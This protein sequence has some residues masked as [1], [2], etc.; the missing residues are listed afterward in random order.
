MSFQFEHS[1]S[2]WV[3][4]SEYEWKEATDGRL[5]LTPCADAQPDLYDPLKEYRQ[6]V[7]DAL[8]I[9]RL[10]MKEDQNDEEIQ[11]EIKAFA[12]KYGITAGANHP[13]DIPLGEMAVIFANTDRV[14]EAAETE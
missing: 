3:R 1:N 12:E 10:C 2:T 6:L 13:G 7:L 11:A 8:C 5:Y 9:G 14:F 4:Y